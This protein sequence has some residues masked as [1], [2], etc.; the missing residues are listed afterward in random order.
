M[1]RRTRN[2]L[3]AGTKRSLKLRKMKRKKKT[4]I[5]KK[6]KIR[7]I[8]TK[9]TKTMTTMMMTFENDEVVNNVLIKMVFCKSCIKTF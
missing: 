3:I 7:T 4:K 8:M 6:V 1:R 9:T 5:T 2:R